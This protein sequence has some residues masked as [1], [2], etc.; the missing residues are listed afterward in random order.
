MV[1]TGK[2]GTQSLHFLARKLRLTIERVKLLF[3]TFVFHVT[4]IQAFARSIQLRPYNAIAFSGPI[5]VFVSV[6]LIY[7][8]FKGRSGSRALPGCSP[9]LP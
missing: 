3:V 2:Q 7:H 5:V 1:G 4:S 9:E 6:F 8:P